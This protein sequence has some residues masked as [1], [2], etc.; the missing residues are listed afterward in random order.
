MHL[1]NNSKNTTEDCG[2]PIEDQQIL[3]S[4]AEKSI[5]YGI[6]FGKPIHIDINDYP[7]HLTKK[8][9]SFVTLNKHNNLRG[10]IGVLEAY[11]PLVVDIASNAFSAGFCD[12]RFPPLNA[13]ELKQLELHISIL[14]PTEEMS[15]SSEEDLMSQIRPNIDGLIISDVGKRGTF[16]PSVWETLPITEQFLSNLKMKAG[17]PPNYWSDTIKIERYTTFSFEK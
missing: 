13:S 1:N 3:L 6:E 10:C 5:A 14:S 12:P 4:I 7:Q 8:R 15:F 9:A 17:L 2:Y 16:L 11:R